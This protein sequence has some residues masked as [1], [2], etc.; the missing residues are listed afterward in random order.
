VVSGKDCGKSNGGSCRGKPCIAIPRLE[1]GLT[2]LMLSGPNLFWVVFRR[3]FFW[4]VSSIVISV[5]YCIF[6]APL[7]TQHRLDAT[8]QAIQQERN[9]KIRTLDE[10][11]N[12]KQPMQQRK[13]AKQLEFELQTVEQRLD[14]EL[15]AMQQGYDVRMRVSEA[16]QTIKRLN[17]K[18]V[19]QTMQQCDASIRE[20]DEQF[21][22]RI[23]ELDQQ[24]NARQAIQQPEQ[25]HT[26][27]QATTSRTTRKRNAKRLVL[28]QPLDACLRAL[29]QRHL[30]YILLLVAIVL[31]S[32]T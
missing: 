5:F 20:S 17:D 11:F 3:L 26:T 2:H 15:Q 25:P 19:M 27:K 1:V 4:F 14:A 9:V 22:A 30:H 28:Q 8:K 32:H 13:L 31:C 21:N 6:F 18:Q 10:Q 23:R 12:G 24:F 16:R 7:Q 29:Y